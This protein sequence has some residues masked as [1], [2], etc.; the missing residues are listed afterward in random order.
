MISHLSGDDTDFRFYSKCMHDKDGLY[1][2]W[3]EIFDIVFK[4]SISLLKILENRFP[5]HPDGKMKSKWELV[6]ILFVEKYQYLD[7][8]L[9]QWNIYETDESSSV[10]HRLCNS[11]LDYYE[12]LL[13][14]EKVNISLEIIPFIENQ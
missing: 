4:A 13:E 5:Y 14:P 2:I 12:K 7:P 11:V 6:R 3:K 9:T 10:L 1:F 8:H